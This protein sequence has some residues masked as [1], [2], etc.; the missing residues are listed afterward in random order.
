MIGQHAGS[1][2]D[3][4]RSFAIHVDPIVFAHRGAA[5]F[6]RLF[7]GCCLGVTKEWLIAK[8]AQSIDESLSELEFQCQRSIYN[9]VGCGSLTSPKKIRERIYRPEFRD[10]WE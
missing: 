9:G 10:N 2:V 6:P 7:A 4:R 1:V 3:C 8:E 5:R